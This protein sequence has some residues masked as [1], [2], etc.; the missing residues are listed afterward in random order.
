MEYSVGIPPTGSLPRGVLHVWVGVNPAG[1]QSHLATYAYEIAYLNELRGDEPYTGSINPNG[2]ATIR[3]LQFRYGPRGL[4]AG[5]VSP[6]DFELRLAALRE[7]PLQKWESAAREHLLESMKLKVFKDAIREPTDQLIIVEN[8]VFY[9]NDEFH[10]RIEQPARELVRQVN[11]DV[12]EGDTPAS[13]RT[14]NSHI[15]LASV[16]I[17]Y[18]EY[19]RGGRADA[20]AE[21]AR[22]L[23]MSPGAARSAVHRARQLGYLG[24]AIGRTA[25]H[26]FVPGEEESKEAE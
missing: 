21:V 24:E 23:H 3:L 26:R 5:M 14:Y 17:L 10:T 19:L 9:D 16:A 4:E 7:L 20:S 25:G 13:R 15:R 2:P 11:P 8:V 12:V 18:R 22:N 6:V 1:D